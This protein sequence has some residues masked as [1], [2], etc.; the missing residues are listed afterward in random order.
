MHLKKQILDY[1]NLDEQSFKLIEMIHFK[2]KDSGHLN[3]DA[4]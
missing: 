3:Q 4:L 2:A 1:D